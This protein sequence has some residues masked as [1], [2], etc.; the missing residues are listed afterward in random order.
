MDVRCKKCGKV[1]SI[2]DNSIV[3]KKVHFFCSECSNKIIIDTRKEVIPFQTA[4]EETV[5]P[6]FEDVFKGFRY[7]FIPFNISLGVMY[8]FAVFAL[9]LLGSIIFRKNASF[10][11][12]HPALSAS[13]LLTAGLGIL[14]SYNLL[15]YFFSKII[16]FRKNNPKHRHIDFKIVTYDFRDDLLSIFFTSTGL[17]IL[18]G[19]AV[20]PAYFLG[21]ASLLYSAFAAPFVSVL[22]FFIIIFVVL[23]N[24]AA[25]AIAYDSYLPKESIRSLLKFFYGEFFNIPFY[26]CI[27]ELIFIFFYSI[28]FSITAISLSSTYTF[29]IALISGTSLSENPIVNF[30]LRFTSGS[31]NSSAVVTLGGA[32]FL[33]VGLVI[34]SILFSSLINVRQALFTEAVLIMKKNPSKSVS[35]KLILVFILFLFLFP[36]VSCIFF[37]GNV[38]TA[39]SALL[40]LI[41]GILK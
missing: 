5:K 6:V 36:A 22:V 13:M 40:N 12:S 28:L 2:P 9:A 37:S 1:H 25:A 17:I 29:F 21:K 20:I 23:K 14:F 34:I 8:F 33:L 7:G 31:S 39:F 16:L 26:L 30:F 4:K 19:I 27:I 35:R 24:F 18:A 15:L 38:M 11:L 32:V 10:F 41:S 3:N